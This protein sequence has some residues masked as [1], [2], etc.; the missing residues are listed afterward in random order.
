MRLLSLRKMITGICGNYSRIKSFMFL[1]LMLLYGNRGHCAVTVTPASGGTNICSS[2]AEGGTSPAYTLLGNIIVAENVVGDFVASSTDVLVLNAPS[3]WRFKIDTPTITYYTGANIVSA[4]VYTLTATSITIYINTNNVNTTDQIIVS[5]LQVQAT[6]TTSLAGSITASTY[7]GIIGVTTSTNFGSLSL[8]PPVTPSVTITASPSFTVCPGTNVLFLPAPVNGGTVPTY[9]WK[10]NGANIATGA[11]YSNS[12][13]VSGN[14]ISCVMTSE[15]SCLTTTTATSSN[16]SMNVL[17]GPSAVNGV[18]VTCPGTTVSLSDATTGGT[19]S[20]SNT[21]VAVTSSSGSVTGMAVGTA[22]ISY[23][24]NG[25]PSVST[26]TI[27][28][29]P[30]NP[31]LTTTVTTMCSGNI[32]ELAAT[33]TPYPTTILSQN[34]N[35]GIAPWT[36]DSTGSI[37]TVAGSDWKDCGN[38]YVNEQG[39][40]F[41]PDSSGFAMTNSDTSGSS[42]YTSSKLISPVFSLAGYSGA[43]LT[44]Q[45]AYEYWP[46]GDSIVSVQISTDGG[47]T[48]AT[49]QNY[50]GSNSGS[51]TNFV[52][53]SFSLNAYLGQT[54][55]RLRFYYYCHWGYYWAIDNILITGISS[56]V[57]PEWTPTTYLYTNA[58]CTTA[59]T[60]GTAFSTV[61]V[62][63]TS[64]TLAGAVTYT[65][66]AVSVGCST[67]SSSTVNFTPSPTPVLG[68]EGLCV[69]TTTSLSDTTASGTWSST[70]TGV[71]TVSSGTGVVSGV[72][73]DTTTILYVLSTG[74]SAAAVVTVNSL[75]A[76]ITGVKKVCMG[77]TTNLS[78]ATGGGW[79]TSGNAAVATI[80]SGTGNVST[81]SAGT[82]NIT[83]TIGTGCNA[84][85]TITVNPLPVN[86]SG[87]STV[88]V[89]SITNLT[90]SNTGGTWSSGSTGIATAGSLSGAIT[91]VA[92]GSAII[93]YKLSTGCFITTEVSVNPLL[94]IS[95][96]ANVCIGS[97]TI[98]SDGLTGG[99]W[100]SSDISIG[101]IVAGVVTGVAAGTT[102]ISYTLPTGCMATTLFTVNELPGPIMGI[103]EV[104]VGFTTDLTDSITGGTWTSGLTGH[105]TVGAGT[106]IVNGVAQGTTTIKYTLPT[107]CFIAQS[108]TVN[109]V[110]LVIAGTMILC[111]DQSTTLDDASSGG[112]WQS[113]N[114]SVATIGST[115]LVSSI[116]AGTSVITYTLPTGCTTNTIFSVNPLPTT[117]IGTNQVCVGLT[118]TLSDATHGGTWSSSATSIATIGSVSGIVT[119]AALGNAIITYTLATGCNTTMPVSVDPLPGNINGTPVFCAGMTTTLSDT[120]GGGLWSSSSTGIAVAGSVTGIVTGVAGGT[121]AIT[122]TLPT[123]CKVNEVIT[124]NPLPASINGI[125][126]VCAGFNTTLSDSTAG[127]TWSSS[128]PAIGSIGTTGIVT[129]ISA[130]STTITYTLSTGCYNIL[131]VTV[132]ALPAVI[133]G[134]NYVCEGDSL[135]LS[136]ST[137]GGAWSS[138]NTTNALVNAATGNVNGLATGTTTISYT[139]PIAAGVGCSS[140][141]IVTV[142]L[143]PGTI[144]GVEAICAGATT[145]LSDGTLGGTWVS[146]NTGVATIGS[147]SGYVDGLLAGTSN[148]TYTL[149]DGCIA[150]TVVTI[151]VMPTSVNGI[152]SVCY[153][154]TTSLSDNV[155]GGTW[156]SNNTLIATIDLTAGSVVGTGVGS[157]TVTYGF[158]TGCM[159][160]TVVAVNANPGTISGN[161][162][163]CLGFT[164]NL[165][166]ATTLGIWTSS[167]TSYANIGSATGFVTTTLAGTA[168]IYYTLSTG[169]KAS[170]IIT[171]NP[172]PSVI[173]GTTN[174]CAG[175]VVA[176]TDLLTGGTWTSN[177]T[178]IATVGSSTGLLTGIGSGTTTISYS[179]DAGCVATTIV[180]VHLLPLSI[181]GNS[182]VCAGSTTTLSDSIGG[183]GTWTTS[184]TS[185]ATIGSSSGVLTGVS[186]GTATITYSLEVGCTLATIITV[187]P[188]P[189]GIVAYSNLCF[190]S[191]IA[192]SDST[193]GGTWSSSNSGIAAIGSSTGVVSGIATGAVNITYKLTTGC[194]SITAVTVYPLPV[195]IS[196]VASVC[197]GL[198][199]R[200]SDATGGGTWSSGSPGIAADGSAG[201]IINGITSGTATI[202]YTL[203][204]G[205]YVTD[206]VSVNPLPLAIGGS[207]DVCA[208]L[209]ANLTDPTSGGAWSSGSVGIAVIGSS[210]GVVNGITAGTSNITYTLPTGCINTILFT[211]NPLP[212]AIG[213][214]SNVCQGL[215]LNLSDL[216][217]GGTWSSSN[218]AVGTFGSS[219]GVLTGISSGNTTITYT[220]STGCLITKNITVNPLPAFIFGI[221]DVC[222]GNTATLSDTTSG[223]VWSSGNTSV[224]SIGTTS[225]IVSGVSNG[226]TIITY[227]TSLGCITIYPVTINPLPG[228]ISG[229]KTVCA[230]GITNLSDTL[231]GGL[232]T[233]GSLGIA[234][235][236]SASGAVSGYV[237]GT[238]TITYMSGYGCIS[239]TIVTVNPLP[240]SIS[241]TGHVC[242]GSTMMLTDGSAGGTWSS[243]NTAIT[244]IGSGTG[245]I[246]GIAAG[247]ANITYTLLTGCIT[248]TTITV[249]PLPS[250]IAGSKSVCQGLTTSLSDTLGGGTWVSGNTIAATVGSGSGVVSG[251]SSGTSIVTYTL[252]TGCT[253]TG[254]TTVNPLPSAING[255]TTFCVGLTTN[256]SDPTTGGNWS[257]SN[258]GI[259]IV[260]SVTGVVTGISAGTATITYTLL[261]GCI[262]T[263][264]VTINTLASISGTTFICSGTSTT[265]S[266]ANGSG[267]WSSSNTGAAMIGSST[268]VVTG[269]SSGTSTI[270]FV[271]SPGCITSTVVTV[272]SLPSSITGTTNVCVGLVTMLSDATA[273]GIWSNNSTSIATINPSSGNVTGVSAGTTTVTYTIG[274]GCT[275][276]TIVTVNPLPAII[277]GTSSVCKGLTTIVS[278]ST[279]GGIWSSSN[280][281][282][283][284][285]GSVSGTA[286]GIMAGTAIV[287]Y[288]LTTGCIQTTMLTVNPLPSLIIGTKDICV[289]L[290]S[291]LTDSIAVGTWSCAS[292]GIL[293]VG[294]I[295]GVV[296]GISSGT[297]SIIYTLPTG[298]VNNTIVTINPLPSVIK[299]IPAVCAGLTISLTDSTI[300]GIWISSNTSIATIGSSTGLVAG[301]ASGTTTVTYML[302]TGCIATQVVTVNALPTGILGVNTVCPGATTTLSDI[303][304]G[305]VWSITGSSGIASVGSGS[306]IVSGISAGTVMV[307]YTLST[308]CLTTIV[309]TVNPL[310]ISIAGLPIVCA[311][312]TT[313]LSDG[314]VGGSWSSSSPGI[315]AIGSGTGTVTGIAAGAAIVTYMLATGC[316]TTTYVTVNPLPVTPVATGGY[317]NVC[318]GSAITLSDASA[319]GIWSSGSTV[320][321]AIGSVN[322]IVS[323]VAMGTANITY[324]LGT[325]CISAIRITVNPLPAI[326]T[327]TLDV[328]AGLSVTLSDAV[329]GGTWSSSVAGIGTVNTSG[330]VSGI[331]AGSSIITYTLVTGCYQV[332]ILTVNPLPVSITG[333][334][335]VCT[336][337]ST[338]L[339]D[340]SGVGVWSIG[341]AS[342]AAVGSATGIVTGVSAGTAIITY[343]LPTSCIATIIV[344]VI[345][346]PASITGIANVCAGLTTILSDITPGGVWSSETSS[347]ATVGSSSGIVS[348]VLAGTVAISYATANGCYAVTV[349]TVNPLP[350]TISGDRSICLGS[351]SALSDSL[352]GGVWNITGSGGIATIGTTSGIVNGLILGTASVTYTLPTGCVINAVVTVNPYPAI[353]NGITN[354]CQGA[355]VYLSD[356]SV[357]GVW[358]SGNTS[359]AS[360]N[361]V[362]GTVTGVGGGSATISYTLATGCYAT[363]QVTVNPIFPITGDSST[364]AG[365]V[366]DFSDLTSGGVWSSS[367]STVATIT[368]TTGVVDAIASGTTVIYY[369]LSTGCITS[370]IVTVNVLPASFNVIG[371]GGYCSGGAG[372]M[373]GLNGS[374]TG[375]SYRLYEGASLI[376]SA[377]GTGAAI[378]YG[379]YSGTGDYII[380]GVNILTGCVN[381]MADTATITVEP[382]LVPAVNITAGAGD[383]ICTG[384]NTTFTAVTLNGGISPA[385]VWY[386]NGV[387]VS[388]TGSTYNFIPVTGDI[389]SVHLTSDATC[390]LPDTADD[391]FTVTTTPNVLSS[392]SI[393]AS[394]GDTICT[395]TGVTI[396]PATVDGGSS[397]VYRWVKNGITAAFGNTY[398][399][400]PVNGDNISCVLHSNYQCLIND[401]VNSS[402]NIVFTVVQLPTINIVAYPGTDIHSGQY[403]TLIA[404]VSNGGDTIIYQWE[405]NG[406]AIPGATSDTFTRNSFSNNDT[407]NCIVSTNNACSGEPVTAEVIITTK[408]TGIIQLNANTE[409]IILVPNPNNG[410]FK[411]IGSIGNSDNEEI[412]MEI[413]DMLGQIVIEKNIPVNNGKINESVNLDSKLSN[414]MYLLHLRGNPSAISSLLDHIFHF[415]LNR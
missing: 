218:T 114:P 388:T 151:N 170:K 221:T 400:T 189:S 325:G 373:V 280:S 355:S 266:D 387:H 101:T 229:V 88:C 252:P 133:L 390:A 347:I 371:G 242:V 32:T 153:G 228:I 389:V 302:S 227:T 408:K 39:Q 212:L 411:I 7:P 125:A 132:S 407:V 118:N 102:T 251:I 64:I 253:V 26:I 349:Y 379:P 60:G 72:T 80:G 27:N 322:G 148:V 96:T 139:I 323:G 140:S 194:Q 363:K 51:R 83:Y 268:G 327:G 351:S 34:F 399:C 300:G 137:N 144:N 78:D 100:N 110:P 332:A 127:G 124:V 193:N 179:L 307:T 264:T 146:N 47:S 377:G 195:S 135:S 359:I 319:G 108:L 289:G 410:Q 306:G 255:N 353:I 117:I 56:I 18:T 262:A 247:S 156:T 55:L 369:E 196:G 279:S 224:A 285:I 178:S 99:T 104:C 93:T 176:L 397:P 309:V 316:I 1:A 391:T 339:S 202:S 343:T 74:C 143:S 337:M 155:S 402:N 71:A 415:V 277:Y 282:I 186:Q 164:T 414:G 180:T 49:M 320:V 257:S 241:G 358:S 84:V 362:T 171:V 4:T 312:L 217:I 61:Y 197:A 209:T 234:G 370:K 9:Q 77:A 190:S 295:S 341:S 129:G 294:S 70:N 175:T 310:P 260:G 386:V 15:L 265:L 159:V 393:S 317:L 3:G 35:S 95:G 82:A 354:V 205:C 21:L 338:I 208:G 185:I 259:A 250:I 364:C 31:V 116:A 412:I 19:W 158:A 404:L 314:T 147:A 276:Y 52:T 157:T 163:I 203:S 198:S 131:T 141:T 79:W 275:V 28:A 109:P 207:G 41:S 272:N 20:S 230:G 8:T 182:I 162:N 33:G 357:T 165:S 383:T 274:T 271:F 126:A 128:N 42:S 54:N 63:P 154:L 94:P 161:A 66:T 321:A 244:T 150:A 115:G 136:D 233:S 122:Y 406:I 29:P 381:T 187:N 16:Y 239:T 37:G 91:G 200:L 288:K 296:S 382:I 68:F 12:G 206:I 331:S 220:L 24:S 398:T 65:A 222:V 192:L 344:T 395:H 105:A 76:S 313:G 219:S 226:A 50:V 405:I 292:S 111:A 365:V 329:A 303:T 308:G 103:P 183:G 287:T 149:S 340:V 67:E 392:V 401:S 225:G 333:T 90:D 14:I 249:N 22:I 106:G 318:A 235:V 326:I 123:G 81:V 311:G 348:G 53:E 356:S 240:I 273:G 121:A 36:I 89:G 335:D 328:C 231:A 261:T 191:S 166:D 304:T 297:A 25:C 201:G 372:V 267:V 199:T 270:S 17:S 59:Y 299:G 336:G 44:F 216:S 350:A 284:S 130:G 5:G 45:Q 188:L 237:Q 211:V 380:T 168:T 301:I 177:N 46:A 315:A 142:N 214:F 210:T 378:Y 13:F 30:L 6:S 409:N 73:T 366:S 215:T 97:T 254:I 248:S 43:T 361:S 263:I 112:A 375:I 181:S 352:A 204:T 376:A 38:G 334:N 342:V 160:T 281:L 269:N 346:S 278:D 69:G 374:D 62:H 298:C 167:N 57:I 330:I 172:Q 85:V 98:L 138:S 385:Y 246:S 232:W 174:I 58:A 223:G 290:T 413:T 367:N 113:G 384:A 169:C 184:N 10:L 23:I 134:G 40:Y 2:S 345:S 256:L 293:M 75:P 403:D 86:I 145:S 368:A 173:G 120:S 286:S 245:I 236:G 107:G 396:I 213:G 394:P 92:A 258:T 48:W 283:A 152:G 238:S 87:D 305:G 243:G 291:V 11:T 324:T 119:G 360:V